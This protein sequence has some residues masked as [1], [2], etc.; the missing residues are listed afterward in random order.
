M[1]L[2]LSPPFTAL[3]LCTAAAKA[4]GLLGPGRGLSPSQANDSLIVANNLVDAWIPKKQFVYGETISFFPFTDKAPTDAMQPPIY[5]IGP[6]GAD[7]IG[8]RPTKITRANIVDNAVAPS[9]FIPLA[10]LD[11]DEWAGLSIEQLP[12]TIPTAM[13]CDNGSPN[14]QLYLW[15]FP[16]SGFLLQ[17][18]TWVQLSFIPALTTTISVQPAMYA[19]FVYTLAELLN[20]QYPGTPLPPITS[21]MAR[22]ARATLQA[23]NSHAPRLITVDG[24]MPGA[25][26][27]AGF[28]YR[29]GR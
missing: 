18:F 20:A 19:A 22:D 25:S 1:P 24:G 26:G 28:N 23:L 11:A 2:T 4:G 12:T 9:I 29:T 3:D 17:L 15:G 7:F 5:T 8:P 14:S 10:I 16:T 6:S 27:G 13:Y 21:R